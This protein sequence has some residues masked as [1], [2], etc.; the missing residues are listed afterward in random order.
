MEIL[1]VSSKSEPKQVAGAIIKQFEDG[2]TNV[3]LHSIGAAATNQLVKSIIIARTY[4]AAS[5]ISFESIEGF[6]T[7]NVNGEE[8]TG[9]KYVLVRK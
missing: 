5:A 7:I 2:A 4:A 9:I 3:E 6:T 1:K 8:R